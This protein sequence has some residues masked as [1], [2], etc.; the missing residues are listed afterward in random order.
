MRKATRQAIA[1]PA[2]LRRV[3]KSECPSSRNARIAEAVCSLSAE[4]ALIDGQ[5]V[6]GLRQRRIEGR[7]DALSR[8]VRGVDGILFSEAFEAEGA[9]VFRKACEMGLEGIVSKRAGSRYW[10]GNSRYWLK[11]KNP[12]FL[13]E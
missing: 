5:A 10:S 2:L 11:L 13:R 1:P 3:A 7:R 6:E 12:A 9:I 8:L 4:S